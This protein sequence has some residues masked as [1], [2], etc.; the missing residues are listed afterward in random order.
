MGTKKV[1]IDVDGTDVVS[2]VLLELLNSFPGLGGKRIQFCTLAEDSGFGFYPSAGSVIESS[3]EDI[4]GHVVQ[5]CTYPFTLVYRVAPNS[6]TQ[7]LRIKALLDA[8]GRW[9][10]Q[11]PVTID[12]KTVRLSDYPELPLGNRVIKSI[13]RNSSGSLNNVSDD[14]VEDWTITASVRYENQFDK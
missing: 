8:I 10:E 5:I 4:M 12:G 7:R 3:K 6:E 11:Q 13:R 1:I 2:Q 14:M 9:L